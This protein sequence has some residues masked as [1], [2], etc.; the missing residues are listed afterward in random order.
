MAIVNLLV[1]PDC[2]FVWKIELRNKMTERTL[3]VKCKTQTTLTETKR[4]DRDSD[5]PR[6][7][8]LIVGVHS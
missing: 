7:A 1:V 3:F 8:S 5:I 6:Q 4:V 2:L